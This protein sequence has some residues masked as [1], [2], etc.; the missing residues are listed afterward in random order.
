M[1]CIDNWTNNAFNNISVSSRLC[2][3]SKQPEP[4]DQS[5]A[6]ISTKEL[7]GE[8]KDAS[9]DL[10]AVEEAKY[11]PFPILTTHKTI[12]V[13]NDFRITSLCTNLTANCPDKCG[14]T[15]KEALF[16]ILEYTDDT[17]DE[18]TGVTKKDFISFSIPEDANKI[19]T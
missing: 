17:P 3:F 4:S 5:V 11:A 12:A 7:T 14:N 6:L 15:T 9:A 18:S 10:P 19:S 2:S 1:L 8:S 16:T 13:F